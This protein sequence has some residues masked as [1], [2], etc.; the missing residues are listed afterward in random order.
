MY[1]HINLHSFHKYFE[2]LPFYT[3][4]VESDVGLLIDSFSCFFTTV[5]MVSSW[6]AKKHGKGV[7][8]VGLSQVVAQ[9]RRNGL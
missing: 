3:V 1:V 4:L 6:I 7:L 9:R 8:R 5:I 2:S